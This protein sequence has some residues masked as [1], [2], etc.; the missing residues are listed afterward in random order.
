MDGRNRAAMV[1]YDAANVTSAQMWLD[2]QN[3]SS[4]AAEGTGL[5]EQAYRDFSTAIQV[6]IL[7]GSLLGKTHTQRNAGS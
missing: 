4:L 5:R 1:G 2:L 6:F 7:V 3:T